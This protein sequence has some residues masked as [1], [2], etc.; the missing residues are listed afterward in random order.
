MRISVVALLALA[1]GIN[2]VTNGTSGTGTGTGTGTNGTSGTGTNGTH[3]TTSVPLSTGVSST[4]AIPLS[5]GAYS[6]GTSSAVPY[7]NATTTL[8]NSNG[9]PTATVTGSSG[10]GVGGVGGVGGGGETSSAAASS[11]ATASSSGA[12]PVSPS[13]TGFVPSSLASFSSEIGYMAAIAM[14]AVWGVLIVMA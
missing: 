7:S 9:E 2:A 11:T 13:S 5:T 4:A 12:S 6:N 3:P 14:S 8:T 10:G 1:T